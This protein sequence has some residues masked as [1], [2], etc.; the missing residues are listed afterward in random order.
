MSPRSNIPGGIPGGISGA[1]PGGAGL[2]DRA[3]TAVPSVGPSQTKRISQR[4]G[5]VDKKSRSAAHVRSM[6]GRAL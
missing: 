3:K 1:I 5:A 2:P 4:P 6:N